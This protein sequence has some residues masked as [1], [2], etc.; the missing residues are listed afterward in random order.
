MNETVSRRTQ[1]A[2][3][4]HAAGRHR[5][6]AREAV[7]RCCGRCG[8]AILGPLSVVEVSR[9]AHRGPECE[10]WL[11]C[12]GCASAIRSYLGPRP[13]RSPASRPLRAGGDRP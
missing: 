10:R 6:D 8:S 11:L 9:L 3:T 12:D 5:P 4:R 7:R 1:A 13:D 2:P